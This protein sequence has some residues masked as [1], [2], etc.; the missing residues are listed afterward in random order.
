M[1]HHKH[2]L[3]VIENMIP[4]ERDIYIMLISQHVQQENE[5]IMQQTQRKG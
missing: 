2:S 1:H 5:K 4:F 3:D